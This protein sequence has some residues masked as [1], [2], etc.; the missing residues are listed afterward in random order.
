MYP[1]WQIV[2][3]DTYLCK[4]VRKI[5]ESK[6][7]QH[8]KHEISTGKILEILLPA[9]SWQRCIV[10]LPVTRGHWFPNCKNDFVESSNFASTKI[11]HLFSFRCHKVIEHRSKRSFL[12][13]NSNFRET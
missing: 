4:Y 5:Q 2:H 13:L 10:L 11:M 8:N 7:S 9:L 12:C 3:V 1:N 6:L